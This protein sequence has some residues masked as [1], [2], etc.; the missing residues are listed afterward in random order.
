MFQRILTLRHAGKNADVR[1]TIDD[2][3]ATSD[4]GSVRLRIDWPD[5]PMEHRVHGVDTIQATALAM[6]I[7]G[8]R[9][10]TSEAH[11]E[12]R[13]SWRFSEGGYGFPVPSNLEH[14]LVGDDRMTRNAS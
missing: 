5:A 6:S 9:L 8:A 7:A 3:R 12:G 11:V 13:L 2:P 14:L 4:E 10:Y 1:V